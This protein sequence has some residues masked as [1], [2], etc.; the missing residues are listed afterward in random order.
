MLREQLALDPLQHL[1]IAFAEGV[2]GRELEGGARALLHADQ[3]LLDGGR[4]LA[5]AQR[6]VAG[7]SLEGVDDVARRPGQPVVQGQEGVRHVYDGGGGWSETSW[8]SSR[9]RPPF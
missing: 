8:E 6:S 2:A 1:G 9:L 3:A 7:L 4:E 5:R